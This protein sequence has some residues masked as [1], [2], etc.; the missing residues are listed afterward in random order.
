[1]L[2]L[3]KVRDTPGQFTDKFFLHCHRGCIK[4]QKIDNIDLYLSVSCGSS[5]IEIA[6]IQLVHQCCYWRSEWSF[7]WKSDSSPAPVQINQSSMKNS[8]DSSLHTKHDIPWYMADINGVKTGLKIK[9][10]STYIQ[11][12]PDSRELGDTRELASLSPESCSSR[13]NLNYK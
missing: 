1:M 8:T 11:V 12:V 3:F 2:R 13:M 9:I 7:G 4:G 10:N 6:P 5:R